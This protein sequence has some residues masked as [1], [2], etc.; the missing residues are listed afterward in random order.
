MNEGQ[1]PMA[2]FHTSHST[3]RASLVAQRVK[4]LSALW[5]NQIP[6]LGWEEPLEKELATHSSILAW[7]IP[8]TEEP[9]G[10]QG[11]KE[12]DMTEQLTHTHTPLSK[13]RLVR[14]SVFPTIPTLSLRS[15]PPPLPPPLS[16]LS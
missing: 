6:S 7:R 10:L 2:T 15:F 12:S 13:L 1:G 3:F 11:C 9:G 5:K 14:P 16:S 4:N 8:W